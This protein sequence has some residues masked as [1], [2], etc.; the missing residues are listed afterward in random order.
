MTSHLGKERLLANQLL[1]EHYPYFFSLC[2]RMTKNRER[3]I[4]YMNDVV[5]MRLPHVIRTYRED[6]GTPL[7][8]HC[9]IA[10]K[11]YIYKEMKSRDVDHIRFSQWSS[12]TPEPSNSTAFLLNDSEIIAFLQQ[13]LT[14]LDWLVLRMRYIEE[15][16]M[17]SIAKYLR[18]SPSTV[19][20][21]HNI[22][23]NRA[24]RLLS[25]HFSTDALEVE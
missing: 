1:E 25:S 6:E 24:H 22:A 11:W 18:V 3:A 21:K 20:K 13:H 4:E 10:L 7:L 5:Y 15:E 8:A 19:Y 9:Y 14:R 2:L 12:E 16:T 17:A 23:I